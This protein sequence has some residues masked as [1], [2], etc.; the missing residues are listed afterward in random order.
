MLVEPRKWRSTKRFHSSI[1][2]R[3]H[4]ETSSNEHEDI[5]ASTPR[6][7]VISARAS[8]RLHRVHQPRSNFC[9]VDDRIR[10]NLQ[11]RRFFDEFYFLYQLG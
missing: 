2:F 7:R 9:G 11:I 8:K 3:P 6:F 5:W 1:C 10:C 4:T